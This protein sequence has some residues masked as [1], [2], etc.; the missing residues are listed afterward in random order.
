MLACSDVVDIDYPVGSCGAMSWGSDTDGD[1]KCT[2]TNEA[3]TEGDPALYTVGDSELVCCRGDGSHPDSD[4]PEGTFDFMCRVFGGEPKDGAGELSIW[5]MFGT[6]GGYTATTCTEAM[7]GYLRVWG[8]DTDGGEGEIEA[9]VPEPF[10]GQKTDSDMHTETAEDGAEYY[11]RY[12]SPAMQD[13]DVN[14]CAG[15]DKDSCKDA[16]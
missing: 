5:Q 11:L 3:Y 2:G 16:T 13:A 9:N 1:L 6:V 4:K 7:G 10:C 8:L 15:H 12:W 14:K